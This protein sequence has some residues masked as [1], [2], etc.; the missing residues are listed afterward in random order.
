ML[1]Q[2]TARGGPVSVTSKQPPR[3]F[4]PFGVVD[5]DKYEFAETVEFEAIQMLMIGPSIYVSR[6]PISR[7]LKRG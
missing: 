6:V 1:D 5:P 7:G 2:T 4:D 3:I